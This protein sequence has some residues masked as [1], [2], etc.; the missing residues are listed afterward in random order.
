VLFIF[1]CFY[2]L[3]AF[4]S[5]RYLIHGW[6]ICLLFLGAYFADLFSQSQEG[7]TAKHATTWFMSALAAVMLVFILSHASMLNTRIKHAEA[8]NKHYENMAYFMKR[9]IPKGEL[10]FHANWSD[11]QY[12]IGLNPDNDYYVTLDPIYMYYQDKIRYLTYR[13]LAFG[14]TPDPYRTLKDMF[15][16]RFGYAG[17]NFFQ[18]LIKQVRRDDRFSILKEDEL[19]ILFT[20]D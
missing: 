18:G 8:V 6:P 1:T 17:K 15:A 11:S 14:R 13:E 16:T 12:F 19:G 3:F 5:Q 7:F 20:L 10:I 2:Y 4:M 9:Y